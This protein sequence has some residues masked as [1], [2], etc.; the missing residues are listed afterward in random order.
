MPGPTPD[1]ALA[2]DHLAN[3]RTYLAWLRTALAII[4]FG[5]GLNRFSLYLAQEAA[6]AGQPPPHTGSLRIGAGMV[7]V[8]MGLLVWSVVRYEQ[9][10]R[11]LERHDFR[12]AVRSPWVVA[13]VVILLAAYALWFLRP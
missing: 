3:E 10:R 4:A 12:A 11:Q 1:P 2:R 6:S 9:V 8:G 13:A 5:I 7:V